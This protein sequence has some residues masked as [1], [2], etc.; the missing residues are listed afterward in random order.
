MPSLQACQTLQTLRSAHRIIR[1]VLVW[2]VLS[3]GAAIASPLVNPQATELICTGTGVMKLLVKNADGT[4][5]VG[6]TEVAGRMLDCPLC[7]A[8][9]VPPPA[10]KAA[11]EPAQPPGYVIQPLPAAHVAAHTAA[12]PPGRGPPSYA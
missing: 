5:D 3:L 6:G 2:F 4:M 12:P 7:A 11:A 10:V 9:S 8:V 1:F